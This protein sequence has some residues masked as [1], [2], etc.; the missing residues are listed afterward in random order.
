MISKLQ[1]YFIETWGCPMNVHDSE[2]L[3]EHLRRAGLSPAEDS[4]T[5][6]IVLLNTCAVREKPVQKIH[7]RILQLAGQEDPPAIAVCGCVAQQEG[8]ALLARSPQVALVLGPRKIERLPE[9]LERVAAGERL[10]AA[11]FED[12]PPAQPHLGYRASPFRGFVTVTEGCDEFCTFCVVPYT[13]GREA[14]RPSRA[15]L[16]EVVHLDA[17]GFSEVVLLGQTINSYRCPE[18]GMGFAALLDAVASRREIPRIRFLT[19]HPRHFDDPLI[20]TIARHANL[21]RYLHLPFQA[22]SDAILARMKRR[23][24]RDEYLALIERIRRAVPDANLST[25]VIVGFPGETE[26]D[27]LQTLDLLE[28]VRFGQVFA[29]AFS[30][31]PRTPAARYADAVPAEVKRERL[32]Q[33]FE[34]TGRIERELNET[35]VGSIQDVL[36]EG[37]SRRSADEWQGR[38][39]DSRVVNFPKAGDDRPGDIVPVRITAAAAHSLHGEREPGPARHRCPE[40]PADAPRAALPVAG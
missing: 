29:F 5:A 11:G 23:Y 1:T 16:S 31:R 36:I 12:D 17:A 25:D 40:R 13:R 38:G 35:L 33:L 4:G 39:E 19:S 9:L 6:D 24:T 7:N 2:R 10:V 27:F 28:T 30:P 21:S 26:A 3:E 32:H 14:S 37:E 22:G 15:I 34:L 18:T 20:E 8:E